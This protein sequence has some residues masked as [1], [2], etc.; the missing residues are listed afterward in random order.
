M[1]KKSVIL[2]FSFIL[3]VLWGVCAAEEAVPGAATEGTEQK[4]T[5]R[6]YV[7]DAS[8]GKAY[9]LG[10]DWLGLSPQQKIEMVELARRGALKLNAIV[11]LPA[12]IYIRELD[13]M[14][15]EKPETRDIEVGQAIQG[16]A[17]ALKDWDAGAD[18]EEILEQYTGSSPSPQ[19]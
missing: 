13:Q 8:G 18:T 4:K 3:S 6:L 12:E 15:L 5:I 7:P 11:S 10:R 14:F 1:R 2:A 17:I 19:K 9:L 16:V